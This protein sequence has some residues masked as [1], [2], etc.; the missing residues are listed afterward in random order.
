MIVCRLED[1]PRL[2][3]SRL[4]FELQY[5]PHKNASLETSGKKG[6][7]LP[8]LYGVEQNLASSVTGRTAPTPYCTPCSIISTTEHG[9]T[10][11]EA[12]PKLY[13]PLNKVDLHPLES[14]P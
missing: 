5:F 4:S 6:S 10:A 12:P 14:T 13:I 1:Y 7:D 3:F 8:P 11:I 9:E 2:S